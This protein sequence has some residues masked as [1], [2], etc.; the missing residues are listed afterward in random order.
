MSVAFTIHPR[1]NVATAIEDLAPGAVSIRGASAVGTVTIV[2]PV[3]A[4]HKIALAAMAAG[5]E[6]I[7]YGCVIGR[8]SRPIAEGEWV[9]LP[10]LA[11]NYDARSGSL[12]ADTGSPTDMEDAYR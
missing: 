5:E 4:G 3:K 12:D 7:K 9:H 1:D 6:V 2:A 8:A 11:S 10:N